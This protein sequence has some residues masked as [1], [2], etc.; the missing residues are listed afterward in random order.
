MLTFD[1][2]R[3]MER[4]DRDSKKL[5]KLPEDIIVQLSEYM[6]RK[7]RI[8]EKT[9]SDV[10]ELENVKNTVKRFFDLREHKIVLAALDAVRTGMPAE[11]MTREE[12]K[13][14]YDLVARLQQF[15]QTF[16]SE[17]SKEQ[18]EAGHE[19]TFRV[20]KSLPEFV[21]PDM[22][23]YKLNENDFVKLPKDVEELL[24]KKGIIEKADN[25]ENA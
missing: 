13:I 19:A 6:Q 4:N 5:Q 23:I 8:K 20:K 7:E 25:N 17:L 16:F 14:F 21:G 15:R 24:L 9:A 10:L 11:N 12:E 1:K 3:E 2:I 22:K 18:K